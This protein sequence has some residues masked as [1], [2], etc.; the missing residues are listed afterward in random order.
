MSVSYGHG[1][2]LTYFRV[3]QQTSSGS[4]SNVS[5]LHKDNKYRFKVRFKNINSTSY[6]PPLT[7]PHAHLETYTVEL[8]D[9][10]YAR[11]YSSSSYT[12]TSSTRG[13]DHGE[14]KILPGKTVDY[15]FYFIWKSPA[16]VPMPPPGVKIL[17]GLWSAVSKGKPFQ[18]LVP[19]I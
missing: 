19:F 11:F 9:A 1:L 7:E 3:Q 8:S 15:Y 14:H 4:W 10:S 2:E 16:D 6:M 17:V 12:G 18:T 13:F 5:L